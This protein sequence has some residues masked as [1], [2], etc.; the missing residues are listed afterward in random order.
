[1][2]KKFPP[3]LLINKFVTD[4]SKKANLFNVSFVKQCLV[5]ENN[6][7][8]SSSTVLVTD[9][10]LANTEFTKD[11][12]KESSVNSILTKVLAC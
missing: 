10:Y 5:I 3:I 7:V 4:L 2:A 1:M 11:D 9:Q 6:S 8:L 12:I